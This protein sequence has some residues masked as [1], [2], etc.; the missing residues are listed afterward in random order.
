M[1]KENKKISI[2]ISIKEGI[3]QC[4]YNNNIKHDF[5]SFLQ[6]NYCNSKCKLYLF[7]RNPKVPKLFLLLMKIPAKFKNNTYDISI[8]VYFPLNF[9][10]IQPD[11]F[12]HKYSSVKINP[13]CLNYIDEETLKINY[14]T[15]FKWEYSFE[16][17]KKLIKEIYNKFNAI[18]PIF[19]FNKINENENESNLEKG[20]CYLKEQCCKEIDLKN[21]IINS[22]NK[23]QIKNSNKSLNKDKMSKNKIILKSNTNTRDNKSTINRKN[24]L[25]HNKQNNDNDNDKNN[26]I[27]FGKNN[28][29]INDK[30]DELISYDEN[31]VKNNL[32]KI[33]ISQFYPKISK[34]NISVMNTKNNLEKTKNNILLEMKEFDE[35]EKQR[36]NV[37]KSMNLMKNELNNYNNKNTLTNKMIN[38]KEKDFSNLDTLLNIKN[39]KKYFLLS[40]EKTIEEYMLVIKKAYEKHLID[41][42]K[43][44]Q[45]VRTNSIHIFY[46]KYKYHNLSS[47]SKNN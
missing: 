13:N 25:N 15:F 47:K 26:N 34:I 28:D 32:I 23:P 45:I 17:F 5:I 44:M 20:D 14:E 3:S 40:K 35:I 10:M 31:L 30:N 29:L 27:S 19:T 39:K 12:F 22:N 42:E 43:A 9:P 2:S 46:I 41:L 18:F 11:I 4:G 36:K 21:P 24:V 8:L 6:N 33:L 7:E 37:E 16:S 1:S 38:E